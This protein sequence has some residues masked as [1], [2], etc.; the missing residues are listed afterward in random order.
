VDRRLDE[1]FTLI[2]LLVIMV[3]VGVLAAIAIPLFVSQRAKAHDTSTK[4]DLN[5]VGKEISAYF[6]DGS[7]ALTL[8]F[9]AVPGSVVIADG[10]AYSQTVNLTNGTARPTSGVS[11]NLNNPSAWCVALT[12]PKG[13]VGEFRYRASSGLEEGTC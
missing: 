3:V 5:T 12:D 4:A 6:V 11:A 7:G 8:D 13:A 1:G 10:V 9:V 2:E